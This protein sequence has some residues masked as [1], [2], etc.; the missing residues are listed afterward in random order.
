MIFHVIVNFENIRFALG[1][2]KYLF[3]GSFIK[4]IIT[5]RLAVEYALSNVY[6]DLLSD[7]LVGQNHLV[8]TLVWRDT[9]IML[10]SL[11]LDVFESQNEVLIVLLTSSKS[12]LHLSSLT[13]IF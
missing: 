4:A 13:D 5:Y 3:I 7:I 12:F 11:F 10:I 2:S 8:A 9:F 1:F 6:R